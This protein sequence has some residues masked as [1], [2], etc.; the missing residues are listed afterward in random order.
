M[1]TTIADKRTGVNTRRRML[2]G[3]CLFS[4]IVAPCGAVLG[5]ADTVIVSGDLTDT[6]KW[7]RELMQWEKL[8]GVAQSQLKSAESMRNMIGNASSS[9]SKI[10]GTVGK[11]TDSLAAMAALEGCEQYI[12]TKL[13]EQMPG[14]GGERVD[15]SQKLEGSVEVFGLKVDRS[16]IRYAAAAKLLALRKRQGEVV[17]EL[18]KMVTQELE[19]Q[20][21]LLAKLK[22]AATALDIDAVQAALEAS[23]QRI[24]LAR[25]KTSQVTEQSEQM[26]SRVKL[27][28]E[29]K[30]EGDREWAEEIAKK[31]RARALTALHAQKGRSS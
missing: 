10:S 30:Q 16:D 12:K 20:K 9:I 5:V 28:R 18:E 2:V 19:V 8:R 22:T 4:M 3:L 13:K 7:P 25:L 15:G 14:G 29:Q 31:L 21:T 17:A 27:E 23:Q 1:K 6:W 24:D 11:V 26:E